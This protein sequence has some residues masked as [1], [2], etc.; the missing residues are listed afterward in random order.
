MTPGTR[1]FYKYAS[2]DATLAMLENGS[3]RYSTPLAFN[4]PFDVQSGLHFDFDLSTLHSSLLDRMEVMAS[5]PELPPVDPDDVW[6]KIVLLAHEHY[7]QRGFDKPRWKTLTA[8]PF[9]RMIDV[10]RETQ[11]GYQR[12]WREELLPEMRVFCV[13]EERD[14]L[15]MWAHYAADHKGAV[16]EMWSLPEEDNPLSV[17]KPVDYVDTP[18]SFYTEAEWLDD[19]VGIKPLDYRPLYQR[20]AYIKSKHW[21]YEREWRVWYPFSKTDKSDYSPIN[22][23]ELKSI[24]VG[25]RA[26][27][28]F[29]QRVVALATEKFPATRIFFAEKSES[30]YSLR[31][32]KA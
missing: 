12:R 16:F 8:E 13:S 14:N 25:C 26:S 7:P 2:P 10:I 21:S 5:S 3:V 24:Y 31:Y 6:G 28:E 11:K 20:Y 30:T 22:P 1:P 19:L 23:N 29:R 18:P 27:S 4:D 32:A 17:A 15:L 9:E